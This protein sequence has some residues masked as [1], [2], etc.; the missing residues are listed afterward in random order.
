MCRV[1]DLIVML[2]LLVPWA[3]GAVESF[4]AGLGIRSYR[5]RRGHF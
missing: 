3:G 4:R 5:E 2:E 1:N